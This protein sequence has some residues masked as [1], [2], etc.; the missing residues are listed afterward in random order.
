[1]AVSMAAAMVLLPTFDTAQVLKAVKR[2]K[3]TI[4]PGV[5]SMYV[6]INNFPGVRK[7]GLASIRACVS[8]AAPLPLEVQEEFEKLTR[9]RLVEGYG[10]TEAS[11]V[12]HINPLHG[13]RKPGSIGIPLPSTVARIVD[14]Q[15]GA[16]LPAGE[17]GELCVCGP[18]VMKGYWNRPEETAEVLRP[19]SSGEGGPWLY[20]GDLARMDADGFFQ[21][22]DRKKDMILAGSYNVYPRDVEEVLYEHPKVLEAAA[23]GVPQPGGGQAVK[24]FVVLKPGE[25]ATPEEFIAYCRARLAEYAVPRWVEFRKELPRSMIGKVLRRLLLE[26]EVKE[27]GHE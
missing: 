21:V 5:P 24:A 1:M 19:D 7:Y 15:T 18:Q 11:P 2:H 23:V 26:E 16:E 10:L 9:G 25:R 17:I 3:P 13:L 4:F 20:T 27:S 8:G 14:P 6:A 22:I 12:T